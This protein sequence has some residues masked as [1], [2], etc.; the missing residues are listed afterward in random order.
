MGA[1]K[2]KRCMTPPVTAAEVAEMLER[3]PSLTS[4]TNTIRLGRALQEAIELLQEVGENPPF[5]PN[6][7]IVPRCECPA[8]KAKIFL[9]AYQGKES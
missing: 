8:C 3:G 5:F 1:L 2:S 4:Q 9:R 7:G 6:C